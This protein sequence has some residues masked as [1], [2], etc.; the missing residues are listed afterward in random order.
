[1]S[2]DADGNWVASEVEAK[3]NG[4]Y[5]NFQLRKMIKGSTDI[6]GYIKAQN[7]LNIVVFDT[8]MDCTD[9][10]VDFAT[11]PGKYTFSY[12][13]KKN[14]LTVTDLTPKEPENPEPENPENPENPDPVT[15]PAPAYTYDLRGTV[16]DGSN[17]TNQSF[18]TN[19]GV[20]RIVGDIVPGEFGI[21]EKD[22]GTQKAWYYSATDGKLDAPGTYKLVKEGT[23]SGT[24][25]KS[26]LNGS[27]I[28][29]L[30]IAKLEL[31][32]VS[33]AST[34]NPS[35]LTYEHKLHGDFRTADKWI[36]IDMYLDTEKFEIGLEYWYV[37]GLEITGNG[38]QAN[39][40]IKKCNKQSGA[41]EAWISHDGDAMLQKG[42]EY[43]CKAGGTDFK[44]PSGTY[45][46]VYGPKENKLWVK[47]YDPTHTS[48]E[49]IEA[50]IAPVEYY[51]LQGVRVAEPQNGIF[52][53]RQGNRTYKVVK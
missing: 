4:T 11:V 12:N 39:F 38:T 6:V 21:A 7:G 37:E 31:S 48:V 28:I 52:I 10:G 23:A 41:Q 13:P 3:G 35:S 30:D 47:E 44:I 9:S 14:Q 53:A 5:V 32:V 17:W 18:T 27:Y 33:N 51:N 2:S 16:F 42:Q 49:E 20:L 50:A 15:P 43:N 46:L 24:N 26:T 1:M 19:N 36:D 34:P 25:F 22:M 8:P 29:T 40:G 45:T